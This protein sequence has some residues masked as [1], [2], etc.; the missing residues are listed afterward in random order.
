MTASG[1]TQT[2]GVLVPT[3]NR[4]DYLRL[5]LMSALRQ[6]HERLEIV[7]VDNGSTDGTAEFMAT[8][9][10]PRVRY[11]VNPRNLGMAG[12]VNE[13]IARFSDDIEWCTILSDD[14]LLE[15][16]FAAR[17][18]AEALAA[19]AEAVVHSH[20]AF[21]DADGHAIRDALPAPSEEHALEYLDLRSR[22]RRETFLTGV[23][24]RRDAFDAIGGYPVFSSGLASDDAFIFSLALRDR[25]VFAPS[26]VAFVR[27][28][29][30][31]ESI[32]ADDGLKKLRTVQEF[33]A[34]CRRTVDARRDLSPDQLRFFRRVLRRYQTV[35]NT[36][37][38]WTTAHAA[39][40]RPGGPSAEESAQ[41]IAA[42]VE[43][44]HGFSRRIRLNVLLERRTR[45]N[46]ESFRWYRTAGKLIDY[47]TLELTQRAS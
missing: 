15:R 27:F 25:L 3:F 36:H 29:P 5:A 21:I 4:R 45:I 26:A 20:R 18:L 14:D 33:C 6:T 7:V 43:D 35:L 34:Y 30:G 41:L 10:D 16:E 37:W 23:L 22:S 2:V 44:R 11:I 24:F 12:S 13:G 40:N 42:V 8:V 28:H 9:A 19:R 32:S 1:R 38:W 46:P 47:V 39:L 17:S 31:A